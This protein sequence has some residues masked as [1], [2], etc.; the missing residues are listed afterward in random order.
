[1]LRVCLDTNAL[2]SALAFPGLRTTWV[3]SML[4]FDRAQQ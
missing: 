1:V 4:T 2:I 3:T